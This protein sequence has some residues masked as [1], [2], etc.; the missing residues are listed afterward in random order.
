MAYVVKFQD[1]FQQY[2]LVAKIYSLIIWLKC[3]LDVR[4]VG[5][6]G[7]SGLYLHSSLY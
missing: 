5:G 1:E 7:A 2:C 3:R 4:Q 6:M